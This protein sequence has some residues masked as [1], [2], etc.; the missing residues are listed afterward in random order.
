MPI[1]TRGAVPRRCRTTR[2]SWQKYLPPNCAPMPIWFCVSLWTFGL[3]GDDRGRRGTALLLPS[4]G[5]VVEPACVEASLT[6]LRFISA[7]VP[8]I[9]MAR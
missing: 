8:P 1:G 9:T 6:V 3:E 2:T 4:V 5:R 7:E